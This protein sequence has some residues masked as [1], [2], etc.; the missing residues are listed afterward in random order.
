MKFSDELSKGPI[1]TRRCTDVAF[2][3]FFVLFLAGMLVCAIYGWVLGEPKKLFLGWDS[4]QRGCGYSN[5]TLNYPYLY[6]P[7]YPDSNTIDQIKGGNYTAALK[8]LKNSVCVKECPTQDTTKGVKCLATSSMTSSTNYF[9]C[10]Y[11][12]LGTNLSPFRYDTE[13]KLN[14]FCMPKGDYLNSTVIT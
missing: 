13:L 5:Q 4:D 14:T 7:Q 10:Q 11:Y 3:I 6:W 9:Q 1:A 12:P 2:C 8:L